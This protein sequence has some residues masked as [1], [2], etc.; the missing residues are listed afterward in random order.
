MCD[1]A[2]SV[3]LLEMITN[4]ILW[5]KLVEERKEFRVSM[6]WPR[7][8]VNL[9]LFMLT[10]VIDRMLLHSSFILLADMFCGGSLGK[11]EVENVVCFQLCESLSLFLKYYIVCGLYVIGFRLVKVFS[12]L[13]DV[14]FVWQTSSTYAIIWGH[15]AKS[16]TLGFQFSHAVT[17]VFFFFLSSNLLLKINSS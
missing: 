15:N 2:L 7:N 5:F 10:R 3:N 6:Q 1:S 11:V 13:T 8:K 9:R 4:M 17:R 14:S 16:F 12:V